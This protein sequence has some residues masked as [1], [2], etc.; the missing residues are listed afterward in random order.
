MR[1]AFSEPSVIECL[2]YRHTLSGGSMPE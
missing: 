1:I 2:T